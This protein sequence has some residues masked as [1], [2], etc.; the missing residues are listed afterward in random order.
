LEADSVETLRSFAA[1]TLVAATLDLLSCVVVVDVTGVVVNAAL[2]VFEPDSS[3]ALAE[4]SLNALG[5]QA[6][7]SKA[8]VKATRGASLITTP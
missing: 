3:A 1:L 6:Q 7:A 2:F 8:I 5:F 4:L